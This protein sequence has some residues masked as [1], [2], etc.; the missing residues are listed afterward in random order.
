MMAASVRPVVIRARGRRSSCRGFTSRTQRSGPQ[1]PHGEY[2]MSASLTRGRG[3]EASRTM[4]QPSRSKSCIVCKRG[5]VQA[6]QRI[7][8]CEAI[9][10]D[11]EARD[12]NKRKVPRFVSYLKLSVSGRDE[13]HWQ[14]SSLRDRTRHLKQDAIPPR[15]RDLAFHMN[16]LWLMM[17]R[18]PSLGYRDCSEL[19]RMRLRTGDRAIINVY[20]KKIASRELAETLER[21]SASVCG[22]G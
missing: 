9:V 7:I 1:G 13:N 10:N 14:G 22:E 21:H 4:L 12:P 19:R 20:D 8:I 15:Q 6:Y 11:F 18:K 2:T 17:V 16:D 3:F 5:L